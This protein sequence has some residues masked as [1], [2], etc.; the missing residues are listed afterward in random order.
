MFPTAL[1]CLV[2]KWTTGTVNS[3]AAGCSNGSLKDTHV[4]QGCFDVDERIVSAGNDCG[5]KGLIQLRLFHRIVPFSDRFQLPRVEVQD[6]DG[7]E[8]TQRLRSCFTQ[9]RS[10]R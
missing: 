10:E 8:F 4:A 5:C 7:A 2:S 1:N 6:W 3:S 9:S